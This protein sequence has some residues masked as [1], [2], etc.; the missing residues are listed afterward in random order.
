VIASATGTWQGSYRSSAVL[1]FKS[2]FPDLESPGI[3]PRSWKVME[4][5]IAG[6]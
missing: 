6:V 2:H 5:Q 3:W 4:M 1:E